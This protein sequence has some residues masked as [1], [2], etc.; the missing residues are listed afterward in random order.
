[1][2]IE[3]RRA[4]GQYDRLPALAADLVAPVAL[5]AMDGDRDLPELS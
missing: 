5:I 2:E 3:Y 1:V 4:E